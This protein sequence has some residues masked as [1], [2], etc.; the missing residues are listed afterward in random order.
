MHPHDAA[1]F[2]LRATSTRVRAHVA[3]GA[4]AVG[5]CG[6]DYHYD[7]SPRDVQRAVFDAQLRLAAE[8]GRP[9]VVHTR[10]AEDDTAAM[11]RRPGRPG[12]AACFTASRARPASPRWRSPPA[13][14]SR[15]AGS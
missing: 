2:D 6:L 5:E 7:H 13:G 15:S 10:E 14:T 8:A 11:I 9:V 1:S 4:V 3:A 12:S